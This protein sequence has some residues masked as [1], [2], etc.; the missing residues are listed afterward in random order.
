MFLSASNLGKHFAPSFLPDC[1][2]PRDL[3]GSR[4]FHWACGGEEGGMQ[5]GELQ[6]GN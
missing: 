5:D 4:T 2:Y 1:R 6:A 3:S